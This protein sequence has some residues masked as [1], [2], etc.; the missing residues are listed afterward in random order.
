MLDDIR[1]NLK[2]ILPILIMTMLIG[3]FLSRIYQ[4]KPVIPT[5]DVQ[6]TASEAINYI[7]TVAKVCGEVISANFAKEI[8]GNPT[9]LNFGQSHPNQLFTAVIWGQE[10]SKWSNPPRQKYVNRKICVSGT[11]EMHKSTPQ[12]VVTEPNQIEIQNKWAPKNK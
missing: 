3:L 6:I 1:N 9:F 4:P 2:Y 7:G 11:I 8:S 10:Q 5:P 12:I